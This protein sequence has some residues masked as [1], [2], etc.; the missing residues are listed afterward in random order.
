MANQEEYKPG[1]LLGASSFPNPVKSLLTIRYQ[2]ASVSGVI[3]GIYNL[4]GVKFKHLIQN[5]RD[6]GNHVFKIDVKGCEPGIFLYTLLASTFTETGRFIK[7]NRGKAGI[8]SASNCTIGMPGFA[9]AVPETM[10]CPVFC[11]ASETMIFINSWFSLSFF[12][13]LSGDKLTLLV[14]KFC[15][16]DAGVQLNQHTSI[17]YFCRPSCYLVNMF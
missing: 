14:L 1:N 15:C 12:G 3:Q 2:F 10:K 13:D 9:S 6:T 17:C 7:I 4:K 8:L 11:C 5:L 16:A